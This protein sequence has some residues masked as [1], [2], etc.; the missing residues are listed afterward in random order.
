MKKLKVGII[1]CGNISSIY[2][3]N[4]PKFPHLEVVAFADFDLPRAHS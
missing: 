4:C 3:E 1:G 2:M